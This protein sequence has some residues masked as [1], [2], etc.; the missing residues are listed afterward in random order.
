MHHT[1]QSVTGWVFPERWSRA[2]DAVLLAFRILVGTFL[3]WGVWDNVVSAA[4]MAEFTAFL[5]A[6]G[7]VR[8]RLLAPLSVW[9]QLA[10]GAGFLLGLLTRWAGVLCALNFLVALLMVDLQG[11]PRQAFPA[12]M[13][14]LF[15][16]YVA[17]RGGG[18]YAFD[19]AAALILARSGG[20]R[21]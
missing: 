19:A 6:H 3:I 8:P 20:E 15:G 16:L 14:M 2:E 4:R 13:L 17:A 18:R 7:F 12:A 1:R 9:V 10:C 5:E 11:G 21:R